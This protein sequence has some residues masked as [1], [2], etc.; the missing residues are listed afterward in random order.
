[1]NRIAEFGPGDDKDHPAGIRV[2]RHV[3]ILADEAGIASVD[4]IE[5]ARRK[6]VR[7]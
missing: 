5:D 6:P 3:G 2:D 4:A 1:M 7:R